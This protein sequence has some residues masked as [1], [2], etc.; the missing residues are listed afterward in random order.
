MISYDE[1]LRALIGSSRVDS[2][3]GLKV[4]RAERKR[5]RKTR[6]AK[7]LGPNHGSRNTG[8]SGESKDLKLEDYAERSIEL[9]VS[10][11]NPLFSP[12]AG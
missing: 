11:F 7:P 12:S 6:F 1:H 4:A 2:I 8:F 10:K 5:P 9:I 3:D